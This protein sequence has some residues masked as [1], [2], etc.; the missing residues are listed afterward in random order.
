MTNRSSVPIRVLVVGNTAPIGE[1][2]A[3]LL[4]SGGFEIVGIAQ[5]GQDAV[6]HAAALRPDVI[7]MDVPAPHNSNVV[8]IQRIM[9]E[10][11]T[12]IV[13]VTGHNESK[14]A[15]L[16]FEAMRAGALAVL[17]KLPGPSHPRYTTMIQ[18]FLTTVRLMAGVQVVR[19][20]VH[21]PITPSTT[22]TAFE[23]QPNPAAYSL[24]GMH[25]RPRVIA[26]A[27]STGGPQAIQVLLR[28]LGRDLAVPI[29]IVQH[30]SRG[31]ASSMADW[32][33]M[34]CPQPVRLAENGKQ[35]S[36]TSICLAPEGHHLMVTREGKISLSTAPP[37]GSFRPSAT[38]LFESVAAVYESQAVGI[39][40]TG[41]GNDGAAGLTTLHAAGAITI[42]QDEASSVVYGMPRAA[43]LAGA[44]EHILPLNA[45]GPAIRNLFGKTPKPLQNTDS[46]M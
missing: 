9:A 20:R 21:S 2:L 36:N 25:R 11:P 46:S 14:T 40:L 5:D 17:D 15:D 19:R 18:E 34:T 26:I 43:V 38:V 24:G 27:A 31:F 7:T 39:I 1:A 45:I 29:L 12:P 10:T 33:T 22:K 44:A 23:P 37:V 28:A 3:Q 16:A 8:T 41:M 35:L 4:K 6:D 13:V 32:L 42:A 30:I